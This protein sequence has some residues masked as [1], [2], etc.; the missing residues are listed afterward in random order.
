[1]RAA[2]E[3]VAGDH[4]ELAALAAK[5][6]A[7]SYFELLGVPENAGADV[8]PG[9]RQEVAAHGQEAGGC[10]VEK[11]VVSLTARGIVLHVA[12]DEVVRVE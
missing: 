8:P 12:I 1:M 3:A 9:R 4:P 11:E 2:S 6:R 7:G 5:L 10:E